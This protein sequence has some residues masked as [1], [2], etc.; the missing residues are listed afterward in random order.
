MN[1][2]NQPER[3][4]INLEVSPELYAAI[5]NLKQYLNQDTAEVLLK[6]IVLLEVVAA[7]KQEG[8]QV[9]ITDD[10]QNLETEIVG[11]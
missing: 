3:M 5:N 8:K 11:I 6:G 10:N 7:A 2:K 9:W 4:Q 1:A